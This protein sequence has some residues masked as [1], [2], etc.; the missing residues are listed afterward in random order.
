MGS[1]NIFVFAGYQQR[2][3][4]T[5]PRRTCSWLKT[6]AGTLYHTLWTSLKMHLI[7]TGAS[8]SEEPR[9]DSHL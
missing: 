5:I 1:P 8:P 9:Q 3:Q 2:Q 4:K 7:S 6:R